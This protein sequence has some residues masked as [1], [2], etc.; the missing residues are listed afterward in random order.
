MLPKLHPISKTY[1]ELK[2]CEIRI[3]EF[4]SRFPEDATNEVDRYLKL[5]EVIQQ[6]MD[7]IPEEYKGRA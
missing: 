5:Q 2:R 6:A 4:I 3:D 1:T 7:L